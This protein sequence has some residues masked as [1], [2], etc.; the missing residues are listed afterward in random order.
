M[1]RPLPW[2]S[3]AGYLEP[4]SYR[5]CDIGLRTWA[6][7]TIPSPPALSRHSTTRTCSYAFTQQTESST[8]SVHCPPA[9]TGSSRTFLIVSRRTQSIKGSSR[10]FSHGENTNFLETAAHFKAE[11][12]SA[13]SDG[14]YTSRVI[15]YSYVG[16][17][18]S[19]QG[20][21]LTSSGHDRADHK[22]RRQCGWSS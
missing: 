1:G 2:H 19:L 4:L 18:S 9:L 12:A 13:R 22:R 14:Y 17:R 21:S 20:S 8:S 11:Y 15:I 7:D 5:R 3:S 6:S 10:A 16:W